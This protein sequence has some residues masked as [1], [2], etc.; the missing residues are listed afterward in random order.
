MFVKCVR[1]FVCET[2]KSYEVLNMCKKAYTLCHFK[3]FSNTQN[4]F[5]FIAGE[6]KVSSPFYVIE[7][8]DRHKGGTYICTAS[9]GV[10]QTASSQILLHV[11]CEY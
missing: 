10:G 4:T 9:N 2:E 5:L 11:L 7:N 1:V 6:E 3:L 8:M